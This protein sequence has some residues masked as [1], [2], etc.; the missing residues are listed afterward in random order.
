MDE[1]E[2]T[3]V[4]HLAELRRRMLAVLVPLAALLPGTLFA[5]GW[6]LDAL[7]SPLRAVGCE[8]YLYHVTDALALRIG[9]ALLMDGAL[10]MPLLVAQAYLFVAPGLYGRERRAVVRWGLLGGGLFLMGA[11]VFSMV[12]TGPLVRAWHG[13]L[14][15]FPARLSGMKCFELWCALTVLSGAVC[16]LPCV[17]MG[18]RQVLMSFREGDGA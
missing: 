11:L 10:C 8:V 16:A 3:L 5:A 2:M 1:R 12:L 4:G 6:L 13:S 9:A 7:F 14:G 18:L 17:M 15:G